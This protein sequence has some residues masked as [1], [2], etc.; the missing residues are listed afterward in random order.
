M[1]VAKILGI[2]G[3]V[4]PRM[5]KMMPKDFGGENC[6]CLSL[7]SNK[8][9]FSVLSFIYHSWR[10]DAFCRY[11]E[12]LFNIEA[13][14]SSLA[15][16]LWLLVP[17]LGNPLIRFQPMSFYR[18]QRTVQRMSTNRRGIRLLMNESL[19]QKFSFGMFAV[20][21]VV[22]TAAASHC[23]LCTKSNETKETFPRIKLCRSPTVRNSWKLEHRK[24]LTRVGPRVSS[25]LKG[26]DFVLI[27]TRHELGKKMGLWTSPR[28]I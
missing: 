13:F 10:G 11:R 8:I 22:S 18:V 25:R 15:W 17:L 20:W 7:K 12:C 5:F 6:V 27:T 19:P 9:P 21:F 24:L 1:P 28:P 4:I 23:D 2:F 14:V 3:I 26:C 16:L